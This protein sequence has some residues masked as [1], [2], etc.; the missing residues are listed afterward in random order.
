MYDITNADSFYSLQQWINDAKNLCNKDV[1]ILVVGNK[2]DLN[3]E[4][5]ITKVEASVFCA[6]KGYL[7]NFR[8]MYL[9]ASALNGENV[10]EC[11]NMVVKSLMD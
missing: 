11:F 10:D 9:E 2:F 3:D 5:V 1:I 6:D 7:F 8:I 4:R